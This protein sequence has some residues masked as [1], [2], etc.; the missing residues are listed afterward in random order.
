MRTTTGE[1]GGG[2]FSPT[3]AV[4][5]TQGTKAM[6]M[7]A[8]TAN[9]SWSYLAGAS[10]SMCQHPAEAPGED[11]KEYAVPDDEDPIEDNLTE[12]PAWARMNGSL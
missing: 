1:G 9:P 4:K 12:V 10:A 11:P 5:A 3:H 6:P 7:N 8:R 2:A